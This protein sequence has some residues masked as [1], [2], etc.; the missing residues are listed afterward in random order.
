[1][2]NWWH[3]VDQVLEDAAVVNVGGG[4][5]DGKRDA[6][7]IRDDVPLGSGA[8]PVR[9]VRASLLA[10]LMDGT[11]AL[12]KQARL[13][14]M[15]PARPRRSSSTRWSRSQTPASCQS[16]N[17]RQQVMP[18]P[19]PISW[20]SISQ[21]RSDLSTNRMPVSAARSGTRGRPPFGLGRSVGS[22]GSTTAHR[23]SERRGLAMPVESA[24]RHPGSRFC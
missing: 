16:R 14:S 19:Q 15:A 9:R 6:I 3:P 20:G 10:P 17:L 7:G 24:R 13:Q 22:S 8:A 4:K 23:S 2:P 11:L 18:E 5:L 12:S 21:G 1:M